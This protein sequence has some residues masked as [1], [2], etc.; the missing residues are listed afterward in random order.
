MFNDYSPINDAFN[1]NDIYYNKSKHEMS[2]GMNVDDD[3]D[4]LNN[5]I[6]IINQK[7]NVNPKLDNVERQ[8]LNNNQIINNRMENRQLQLK[9]CTQYIPEKNNNKN[10]AIYNDINKFLNGE[11]FEKILE[12]KII[13]ITEKITEDSIN[14]MLLLNDNK[15]KNKN[16]N[17]K[18]HNN[19]KKKKYIKINIKDFIIVCLVCCIVIFLFNKYN[20]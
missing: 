8:Q 15:N 6:K 12:K 10:F 14:K 17:I 2:T 9:T 1:N 16:K 13:K 19:Y 7:Q 5:K 20:K 11:T 18:M 4:N 3:I